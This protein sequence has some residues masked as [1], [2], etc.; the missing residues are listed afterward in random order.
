MKSEED[1][2]RQDFLES[3]GYTI[4]RFPENLII[5]RIDEVVRDI[6]FAIK[7]Q[8]EKLGKDIQKK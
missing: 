6:Y 7:V 3:K 5:H 8:E 4:L 1:R 2:I